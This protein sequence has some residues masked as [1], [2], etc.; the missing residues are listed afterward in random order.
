MTVAS[1]KPYEDARE[2]LLD[3]MR[4]LD[5][6]VEREALRFR[7]SMPK[8]QTDLFKGMFISDGEIDRLLNEGRQTAGKAADSGCEALR[9]SADEF[10]LKIAGRKQASLE[11]GVWLTL[12]RLTNLFGLTSFEEQALLIC[13]APELDGK[14]RK[15]FAYLQ[16][17][18]TRNQ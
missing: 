18:I 13:V 1:F 8:E 15:L 4:L 16:D 14:Y 10:R 12:P 7:R 5:L 11:N 3:E 9:R 17:D 2:H 6:L